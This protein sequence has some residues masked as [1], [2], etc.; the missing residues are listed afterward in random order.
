[1]T[2]RITNLKDFILTKKHHCYRRSATEAGLENSAVL[3]SEKDIPEVQRAAK[4]FSS[5]IRA[6][7]PVIFPD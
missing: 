1:M 3:F 4:N 5:I 2:N 6:E 7:T